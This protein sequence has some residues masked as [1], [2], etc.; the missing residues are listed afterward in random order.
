MSPRALSVLG[1]DYPTRDGTALRDYIHVMDL[2]AAHP[3][4]LDHLV[5]GGAGAQL[6]LGIGRGYTI[7]E[8]IDA[9]AR[10]TGRPVSAVA[11]PRRAGDP[12]ALVADPARAITQ[13]R[14][15]PQFPELD[16]IVGHAWR[17]LSTG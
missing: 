13:L 6:N 14:W 8:V 10:V 1:T 16:I 12:V 11:A 5:A 4:A 7:N 3:C 2:C 15:Q 17:A 9:V